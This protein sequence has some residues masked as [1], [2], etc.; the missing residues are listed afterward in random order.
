[1]SSSRAPLVLAAVLLAFPLRVTAAAQNLALA[2]LDPEVYTS[3]SG[4]F[5]LHVD[6][7]TREG[8]GSAGYRLEHDGRE[9]WSAELPFTLWEGVVADDGVAAGYA[10]SHGFDG[11][12]GVRG[13]LS[14]G[15]F[16]IVIL[17]AGGALRLNQ[18]TERRMSR[19][20]HGSDQPLARG[21]L[22]DP[23]TDRFVVR[24]NDEAS[25]D[26]GEEWWPFRL[27]TGEALPRF[28]LRSRLPN[29]D[30]A[31]LVLDA[32][33]VM[34][35]PLSLV[36]WWTHEDTV[37]ARFTLVDPDGMPV[38]SFDLPSDYSVPGD[39]KAEDRLRDEILRDG[40]ILRCTEP[41]RFEV[42]LVAASKRVTFEV[43]PDPAGS[44]GWRVTEVARTDWFPEA[45]GREAAVPVS[46]TLELVSA[47]ELGAE[48]DSVLALGPIWQFDVDDHER[49]GYVHTSEDRVPRFRL[50]GPDGS[51]LVDTPLELGEHEAHV[52]FAAEWISKDRWLVYVRWPS[53]TN[54]GGGWWLDVVSRH[55]Q[56]I[57]G[58]ACFPIAAIDG[59]GKGGF[60]AVDIENARSTMS[61]FVRACDASGRV[62]WTLIE[63]YEDKTRPLSPEDVAVA[64]DGRIGILDNIRDIVAV[65]AP[66]GRHLETIDL[67]TSWGVEPSYPNRLAADGEV[68]WIV[69]DFNG[70]VP[71]VWMS[72][73]GQVVAR[74]DPHFADGH[75]LDVN[76]RIVAALDGGWWTTDGTAFL[77]VDR[78]GLVDRIAGRAPDAERIDS[79][80]GVAFDALGRCLVGDKRTGAVHVFDES[81]ARLFV[82]T[83][84]PQ[85]DQG[86]E[87]VVGAPDGRV[88]AGGGF[89]QAFTGGD[90]EFVCFSPSGE[91]MGT[92]GN[93]L[94]RIPETWLFQPQG[95]KRWVIDWTEIALVDSDG[96]VRRIDKRPDG[97]WLREASE[98]SVAP[99]GS[100]AVISESLCLY[101]PDGEP[102]KMIPLPEG[103]HADEVAFDGRRIALVLDGALYLGDLD[104]SGWTRYAFPSET[105]GFSAIGFSRDGTRLRTVPFRSSRLLEFRLPD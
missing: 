47:I 88:L 103:S 23:D 50:V 5:R 1:M 75:K 3:A 10:Y 71:L 32:R 41:G 70:P 96:V 61:N 31:R 26:D 11:H 13:D 22:L 48:A 49:F 36:Q 54:A 40:A 78:T 2:I 8:R 89:A 66:D 35:T 34:Q 18:A 79:A 101:G 28:H 95:A 104:K 63:D 25:G 59:D 97:T 80:D 94:G 69:G 6:P 77:H 17:D 99:D 27:A 45:A 105:S 52:H 64:H 43:T 62:R 12:S 81:G 90:E 76:Q 56:P 57:E 72:A 44:K 93:T 86:C 9:V 46:G 65:Y 58:F 33:H 20:P 82:C 85:D 15:V 24:V 7:S 19:H 100:L 29:P 53:G 39:E 84:A 102:S 74:L 4:E 37:G 21:V 16:R 87:M 51:L 92:M 42:R 98:A 60:V 83:P 91:R 55:L 68:G 30:P 67:Q 14:H 73:S 38:W